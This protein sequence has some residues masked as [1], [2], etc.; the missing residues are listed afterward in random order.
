MNRKNLDCRVYAVY[1]DAINKGTKKT[2]YRDMSDYWIDRLVDKT[3]YPNK[4]NEEIKEALRKGA[5]LYWVKYDTI[6]F[7]NNMRTL[8]MEIEDIV[9]YDRHTTFAIKLGKR[10]S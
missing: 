6:T 9:V 1:F 4:S 3:H 5:K 10:V 8:T 2:E 7:H